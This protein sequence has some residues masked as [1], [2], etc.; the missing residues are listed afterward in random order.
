MNFS[1][2]IEKGSLG[3]YLG[4]TLVK[5]SLLKCEETALEKWDPAKEVEL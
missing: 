2:A 3:M 5:H 1:S 4:R